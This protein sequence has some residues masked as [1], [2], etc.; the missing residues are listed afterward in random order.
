MDAIDFPTPEMLR[1]C[2]LSS[3]NYLEKGVTVYS[4]GS[5]A[6]EFYYLKKG[7]IGLYHMLDNGKESLVRIY[8]DQEYF[9]FRTFFGDHFY[10]CTAKVLQPAE[11]VRIKPSQL[12]SFFTQNPKL[13]TYLIRQL[14]GELQDAEHRLSQAS[15]QRTQERVSSSISY[16]TENYPNYHWT[17]REIAE[18]S[19]CETET[20]IR[21]SRLLKK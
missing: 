4:Q 10:H 15:Y 9:G 18:F 2:Q 17:Y 5:Q 7:L 13:T 16:L 11:V 14:A 3:L 19:G 12:S 8:Q 6:Q 1:D 20:A 21:I